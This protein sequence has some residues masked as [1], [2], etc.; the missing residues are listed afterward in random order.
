MKSADP[1]ALLERGCAVLTVNVPAGT[2]DRLLEF[3]RLLVKWNSTYNLTAIR[4][5]AGIVSKHL[6]D[7]LSVLPFLQGR[8]IVDVASGAGLPGIPLALACPERH[9]VLLD[10]NGKKTRFVTHAL[11]ALGLQNSEVVQARAEDY[12][13]AELFATVIS[14][15]FASLPDFMR[16]AG[17]LGAPGAS[18]LAM[19]GKPPTDEMRALPAGF[20]ATVHPLAVPGLKAQR[21]VV[22]IHKEQGSEA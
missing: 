20:R 8:R 17:H 6:L 2:E 11:T 12:R 16:L 5:A 10:S 3:V 21:C 15:A 7:S 4:D 9:F 14:R 13:P 22:E 18:F 1:K 19:K